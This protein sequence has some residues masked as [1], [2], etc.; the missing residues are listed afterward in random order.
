M[1]LYPEAQR[2]AQH[3]LDS[4]IRLGRLPNFED[5]EFL[6]CLN[7]HSM[8]GNLPV[9]PRRPPPHSPSGQA[10]RRIWG[11]LST[12]WKYDLW[13]RTV[14]SF[15]SGGVKTLEPFLNDIGQYCMTRKCTALSRRNSNQNTSSDLESRTPPLFLVLDD[16]APYVDARVTSTTLTSPMQHFPRSLHG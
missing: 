3:E 11:L 14:R 13:E 7:A 8:Q 5:R 4:V 9:A 10:R 15:T 1:V 12:W 16:G 2:E 6:P